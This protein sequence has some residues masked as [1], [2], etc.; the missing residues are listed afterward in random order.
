MYFS[1]EHAV[2]LQSRTTYN[3]RT[4]SDAT[5]GARSCRG[6]R[7]TTALHFKVSWWPSSTPSSTP[8]V[9]RRRRWSSTQTPCSR[10]T[11]TITCGSSPPYWAACRIWPHREG[12]PG[13]TGFPH[14]SHV[15]IRGNEA[16]DEAV[17]RAAACRHHHHH[18][19]VAQQE[20]G[21]VAVEASR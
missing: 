1:Q 17:K 4:E 2:C 21:G 7:R 19:R 10:H 14:P 20:A 3:T 13:C 11:T 12:R 16:A 5:P 15:G 9:A 8:T 18:A 6:G